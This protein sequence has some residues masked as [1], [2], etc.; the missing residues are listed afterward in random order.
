[1]L[2][3]YIDQ[4]PAPLFLVNQRGSLLHANDAGDKL[5]RANTYVSRTDH[6]MTWTEAS[7][8]EKFQKA[9][10]LIGRPN[11]YAKEHDVQFTVTRTNGQ[12][13]LLV[14]VNSVGPAEPRV[15][16]DQPTASVHVIDPSAVQIVDE[17]RLRT[18]YGL[19]PSE[20]SVASLIARGYSTG[21]AASQSGI[22]MNTLR[23]HLKRALEKTGCRRQA[24]LVALVLRA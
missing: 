13:P 15:G 16:V 4:M 17:D 20:A 10:A 19:T 23:T 22:T 1:V 9:L 5:L 2:V 24:E 6:K 12:P 8:Q 7:A 21:E 11:E 18:L 14:L 3:S